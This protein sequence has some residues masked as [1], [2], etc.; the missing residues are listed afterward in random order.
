[1][2]RK[3]TTIALGTLCLLALAGL[4]NVAAETI[5]RTIS[6][7][8]DKADPLATLKQDL[9][10]YYSFEKNEGP[11][12]TDLSGWGNHG[13]VHLAKWTPK[14]QVG[15][16][17]Q[18]DG[19][20]NITLSNKRF[21]DGYTDTTI[22]VWFNSHLPPGQG[23]QIIASGDVRGGNDPLSTSINSNSLGNFGVHDIV[24]NQDLKS[25][26][27][28]AL[29]V[30]PMSWQMIT[31]TLKSGPDHSTYRVYLDGNLIDSQQQSGGFAISYDK[32]MPTQIGAIHGTQGW[33][34]LIDELMVFNRALS[35]SEIKQLYLS[36]KPNPVGMWLSVDFV[37]EIEDFVP[38]QRN[39][40]GSLFLKGAWLDEDGKTSLGWAWKSDWITHQNGKTC[41]QYH[42]KN[43]D[44]TTYLFLPW[45]NGA[46]T[47]RGVKPSYY[48]LKKVSK[49][50]Q[51]KE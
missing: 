38:D 19:K 11:T 4:P 48:V 37:E 46:V 45:L 15:G 51:V 29:D 26:S 47:E 16:A 39:W 17:Y 34:G 14:G 31:I 10:L 41:A 2:M 1:M 42:I 5:E 32:E 36:Q 49:E 8:R 25:K 43:L 21:L 12:V 28:S 18:F 50:P 27:G 24:R 6:D 20:S 44:G 22:C 35:E 9:I 30:H 13:E 7:P 3:L 40:H 23:G 33:V